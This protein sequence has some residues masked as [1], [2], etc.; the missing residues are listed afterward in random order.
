MQT[1]DPTFARYPAAAHSFGV[2]NGLIPTPEYE[3]SLSGL[4]N[5]AVLSP[6]AAGAKVVS[7]QRGAAGL[8]ADAGE[9][10]AIGA[11]VVGGVLLAFGLVGYAG[12]VYGRHIAPP[13]EESMWAWTAAASGLLFGPLGLGVVGLVADK[14]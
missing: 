9:V 13:G 5:L 14:D 3:G 4:G 2:Q 1:F 6:L 7:A 12:Y 8:G 11:G 10:G